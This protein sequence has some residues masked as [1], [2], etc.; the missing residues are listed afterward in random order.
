MSI[1]AKQYQM[2][3]NTKDI[4]IL[5][6][7]TFKCQVGDSI[8][9]IIDITEDNKP[10]NLTGVSID[11]ITAIDTSIT[12][13][14]F[15]ERI[16]IIDPEGGIL[17]VTPKTSFTA[18]EGIS[19]SQL[20]IYDD[21]ETIFTPQFSFSVSK[22]LINGVMT[23]AKDDIATLTKLHEVLIQY[24]TELGGMENRLSNFNTRLINIENG[25]ISGDVD[26]SSYYKK[27]ETYSA[28]EIDGK[29]IEKSKVESSMINGNIKINGV[30]KEVYTLPT[31]DKTMVGLSNID[32][33]SD[34]LKP[35]S[36]ATQLELDRINE[37]LV[38]DS[39]KEVWNNKSNFSGSYDD[40]TGKPVIPVVDVDKSYV[41]N[42]L[43]NKVDVVSGKSLVSDTEISKLSTLS[44]YELPKSSTSV[45]GG[46]KIGSGLSIDSNGV[47]SASGVSVDLSG[48]QQKNDINLN[49][50]D[51]TIVGGI[52]EIK[53]LVDNK[54]NV[55]HTH[56]K[57]Q[58]TDFP[59][60][61]IVDVTKSYVD[62]QDSLKVDKV[63]N[64]S[65]VSDT[66]I[67]RLS[68][69][70]NYTHPTTHLPS[71]ITQDINNR[72]V[73]DIEKATWNGK[74]TFN[75]DY[76]A[77]T[78][79]PTIPTVDVDKNYVDIE[80]SKKSNEH[81]HP[82]KADSYIPTWSEISEKPSI[83]TKT[84]EL[85]NDSLF[86]NEEF[87]N[88]KTVEIIDNLQS[89][90]T[91]KALS[92]NQGKI[93]DDRI[94]QA[95]LQ[96]TD[97]I[98]QFNSHINDH[99]SGGSS[100]TLR[101]IL[102]DE[103]FTIQGYVPT[104]HGQIVLNKT[105][106]T[107]IEGQSD[108][109]TVTLDKAPTNNQVV[110]LNKDNSDVTLSAT[111]LTFTPS[112]YNTA[113]TVIITV[114]EDDTDYSNEI[115]NI[116]LTSP[117]VI[118]KTLIA[119][120]TDN[121]TAPTN[122]SA[123]SV[124]LDK[125][126]HTF[127]VGEP[128]Q[129]TATITP[130]N[131]TNK[132]VTW[133]SSDISKATVN[134]NGVV[135]AISEGNCIITVTTT[136]GGKTA[137]CNLIIKAT[138]TSEKEF[139][140]TVTSGLTHMYNFETLKITDTVARDLV[141]SSNITYA[142]E[143][144]TDGG[145]LFKDKHLRCGALLENDFTTFLTMKIDNNYNENKTLGYNF[146]CGD[147]TVYES[148]NKIGGQKVNSNT[149]TLSEGIYYVLGIKWNKDTKTMVSY[150]DGKEFVTSQNTSFSSDDKDIYISFASNLQTGKNINLL[151]Y[152]RQLSNE[153]ISTVTSEI[154]KD[155]DTSQAP[156][157]VK[158]N[159][160]EYYNF[161][162]LTGTEMEIDSL[163]GTNK[164]KITGSYTA[165]NGL[166]LGNN[167]Q[168]LIMGDNTCIWNEL[169]YF[170]KF[171]PPSSS[172][173]G[174]KV[175]ENQTMILHASKTSITLQN[176]TNVTTAFAPNL[177]VSNIVAVSVNAITKQAKIYHNGV[178]KQTQ[179]FTDDSRIYEG[180]YY[181][182]NNDLIHHNLVLY[183]KVLTDS[184]VQTVSIELEVL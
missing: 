115:C 164:L 2:K 1:I 116:T 114:A 155:L 152:N 80:L 73:T 10:K 54:S 89:T 92:A 42:S 39:E 139:G 184:E 53:G 15:D 31:L 151:V 83:P 69:V 66:E 125:T 57:S 102:E 181:M 21:N 79:K 94:N 160:K 172:V 150:I 134:G 109:F 147:K 133:A 121:A 123:E 50:T 157:S 140:T 128:V 58:I 105:S 62:S 18:S 154:K 177:D 141:G 12:E 60:I 100:L 127:K 8:E 103:I 3:L 7:N 14:K 182:L 180:H 64:K 93:I 55:A 81:T 97:I 161:K 41:D 99:T 16:T 70:V 113:Q 153:E 130:S 156:I 124:A 110:I 173:K 107:I 44:N 4:K 30:E 95:N 49:T 75:G 119:T 91:T 78:N 34:L 48:Y 24:Q 51:K 38:S 72:F 77:L 176:G 101:D 148:G 20:V 129:L 84:S 23:E 86:V 82:Y 149:F 143:F 136:D 167:S 166:I 27:N 29:L 11:F 61:P 43:M 132:A 142:S 46:I 96:L 52:N 165:N 63:A 137:T 120:I 106:T 138:T 76:T 88:S 19:M 71:I 13:H 175:I 146:Y 145:I 17:K 56:T 22:S 162:A 90:D 183:D 5:K 163:V 168:N 108:T 174:N 178:L 179:T 59:V 122:I 144:A 159:L 68:T 104:V 135:I 28:L 74:S 112:N 67:T 40:L 65:L 32:N 131:T 126:T 47:V 85:S 118:T 98:N 171:T 45:L 35:T 36:K 158:S 9:F 33:T 169:T 111:S 170:L 26:L 37:R 25:N 117:N 87:V 6:D